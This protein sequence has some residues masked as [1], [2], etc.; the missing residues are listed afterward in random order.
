VKLAS[1]HDHSAIPAYTPAA[2]LTEK[3]KER[4]RRP[5]P[6][7]GTVVR[8]WAENCAFEVR[9]F[10]VTVLVAAWWLDAAARG[11][12]PTIPIVNFNTVTHGI[13]NKNHESRPCSRADV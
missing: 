4:L 3:E 11:I 2:P 7:F 1:G 6:K 12:P 10:G 8:I 5:G 13:C 9:I